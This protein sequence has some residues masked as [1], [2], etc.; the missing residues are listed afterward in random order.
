MTSE[1]A[2]PQ[3]E[4][5]AHHIWVAVAGEQKLWAQEWLPR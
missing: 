1:P 3:V 4:G 2:F 5:G